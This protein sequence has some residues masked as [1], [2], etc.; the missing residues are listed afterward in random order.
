MNA[1][2]SKGSTAKMRAVLLEGGNVTCAAAPKPQ[3][4]R[5]DDVL[6][7][8]AYAGVCR[9]DL[10]V[11]AGKIAV[12]APLVLGHEFAGRVET[13]GSAVS[14]L[15]V[16]DRVSVDPRVGCGQC[17]GCSV[18]AA[19]HTP[20]RLGRERHGCFA[21]YVL[22]PER[23]VFAVPQGL[24][25]RLAAYL[26]PVAAALAV[27]AA[28]G[29]LPAGSRGLILGDN[30]FSALL[31]RLCRDRIDLDVA[32]WPGEL[33]APA[34]NAYDF[35]VET[36]DPA[37]PLSWAVTALG[38]RGRLVLKSRGA[39]LALA[40]EPIVEKQLQL[41][42]ADYGEFDLAMQALAQAPDFFSGLLGREF[43][44]EDSA[45]CFAH[46]Q[47]DESHKTLLCVSGED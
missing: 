40:L 37:T 18:S 43:A 23:C 20:Q 2:Q 33:G 31:L 30:R 47:G 35:M 6:V 44:L 13:V 36:S 38:P 9:T 7:R 21:D 26:E 24:S 25:L 11:A 42:G 3:L 39:A 22:V 32:V 14:G 29:D 10:A 4:G 45:A 46:A 1:P 27:P 5:D 34:A 8:V 15:S 28:L 16:G 19:C 17:A 41:Q 12:T